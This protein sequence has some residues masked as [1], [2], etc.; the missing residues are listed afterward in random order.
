MKR[1]DTNEF[2]TIVHEPMNETHIE[3]QTEYAN[4]LHRALNSGDYRDVSVG[5]RWDIRCEL[6]RVVNMLYRY[7]V[8]LTE[9]LK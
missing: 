2:S 8:N 6:S 1:T 7:N 9:L 4:A 3:S 5:K